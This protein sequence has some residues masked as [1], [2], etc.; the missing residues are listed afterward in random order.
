[1]IVLEEA[2]MQL[3]VWNV[4]SYSCWPANQLDTNYSQTPKKH[5]TGI[6]S[7]EHSPQHSPWILWE[8]GRGEGET[9]LTFPQHLVGGREGL[10]LVGGS[11]G[12][13]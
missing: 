3:S 9:D 13:L 12:D 5:R 8:G 11:G 6:Y 10:H 4:H 1:M 2:V 7:P